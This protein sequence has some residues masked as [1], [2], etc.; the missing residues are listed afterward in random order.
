MPIEGKSL[1]SGRDL[2]MGCLKLRAW[3]LV[4]TSKGVFFV[5]LGLEEGGQMGFLACAG[6]GRGCSAEQG[7]QPHR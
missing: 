7:F 3:S 2:L 1:S 6:V 5:R 4:Q